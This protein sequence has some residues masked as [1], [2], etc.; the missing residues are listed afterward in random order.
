MSYKFKKKSRD[1]QKGEHNE[2][3]LSAFKSTYFPEVNNDD[4]ISQLRKLRFLEDNGLPKPDI[5]RFRILY[6]QP[7]KNDV[8]DNHFSPGGK[9]IFVGNG[10]IL[11]CS[12]KQSKL[13]G[14]F[15]LKYKIIQLN[16]CRL[17]NGR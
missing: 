8:S 16:P 12:L 2:L 9:K 10:T 1:K 7:A 3:T 6:T 11:K 5:E 15:T 17:Y 13:G 14:Y 4:F